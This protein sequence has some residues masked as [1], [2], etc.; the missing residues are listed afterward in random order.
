[1]AGLHLSPY[2]SYHMARR[3]REKTTLFVWVIS[4]RVSHPKSIIV[5]DQKS[6]AIVPKDG[7]KG[8]IGRN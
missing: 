1:M 8:N 5:V 3:Q 4:V 2:T 7:S 6:L